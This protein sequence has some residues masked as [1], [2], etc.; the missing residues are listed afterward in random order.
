MRDVILESEYFGFVSFQTLEDSVLGS[1]E[2]LSVRGD[3]GNP[4]AKIPVKIREIITK[5]L[6]EDEKEGTMTSV[7][8][9]TVREE[10]R[11]LQSELNRVEDLLSSS[12]AER[13]EIG[14]KY[15]ALS[16]RVS[17]KY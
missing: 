2:D 3:E 12:R 11:M 15:N 5:N 7:T 6:T 1:T 13:D 16:E 9:D 14:I 8:M 17:T 4:P 10:N